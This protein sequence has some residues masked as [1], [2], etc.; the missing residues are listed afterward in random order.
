MEFEWD[1]N[2]AESN[3]RKHRVRFEIAVRVFFDPQ[4][5]DMF[6]DREDYGE[7]R[8]KTIGWVNPALLV[9]VY[10]HRGED[11]IRIISARKADAH[12]IAQYR[13]VQY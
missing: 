12:E 11:V 8:W 5:I 4:R 3:F 13:E 9:V 2:K 1:P 10:T 7:D 6:D